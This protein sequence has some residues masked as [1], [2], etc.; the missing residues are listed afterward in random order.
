M[1]IGYG[2]CTAIDADDLKAARLVLQRAGA[3]QTRVWYPK[4]L[5]Q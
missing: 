5:E 1:T 3:R 4:P 2:A